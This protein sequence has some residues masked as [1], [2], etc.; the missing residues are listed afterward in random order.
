MSKS[1]NKQYERVPFDVELAKKITHKVIEGRI[2]TKDNHSVRIICFDK[3]THPGIDSYPIV[4]LVD[5]IDFEHPYMF[6]NSG[7][8]EYTRAKGNYDLCIELPE[9][10]K[11]HSFVV[12]D[13]VYIPEQ[14]N[15]IVYVVKKIIA[16]EAQLENLVTSVMSSVPLYSIQH[17]DEYAK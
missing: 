12:G 9:E 15:K 7:V 4:A 3:K 5:F 17:Y 13:I 16:N 10:V 14:D 2:V 1:T 11:K 8:C 6:F